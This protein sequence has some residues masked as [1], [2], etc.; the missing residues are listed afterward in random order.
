MYMLRCTMHGPLLS[1]L[2]NSAYGRNI[3]ND[4]LQMTVLGRIGNA[5]RRLV[6]VLT[7]VIQFPDDFSSWTADRQSE[8]KHGFR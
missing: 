6:S 1:I 3:G 2:M 8:F 4:Q 7:N 5:F